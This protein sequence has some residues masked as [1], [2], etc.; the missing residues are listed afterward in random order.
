MSQIGE[1]GIGVAATERIGAST[2]IFQKIADHESQIVLAL[3]AEPSTYAPGPQIPRGSRRRRRAQQLHRQSAAVV[4]TPPIP[5][6]SLSFP[7]T[8]IS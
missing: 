3:V 6:L 4:S 8:V 7:H 5:Q 1:T 2:A